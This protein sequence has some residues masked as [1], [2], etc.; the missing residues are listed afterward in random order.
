MKNA[1]TLLRISPELKDKI[2]LLRQHRAAQSGMNWSQNN[3]LIAL[4][5]EEWDRVH[6][7]SQQ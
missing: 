1:N 5:T 7:K 4:I 2:K 6:L 3:F